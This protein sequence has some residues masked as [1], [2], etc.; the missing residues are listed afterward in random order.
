MQ[1]SLSSENYLWTFLP[2]LHGTDDLYG[3]LASCLPDGVETELINLPTKGKQDY[4]TLTCWLKRHLDDSSAR[5]RVLVAESFSGPLALAYAASQPEG[6]AAIVLGA[7]FC[8]APHNPGIALLPLRPLFMIKPP[9][10]ALEHFLIGSDASGEKVRELGNTISTISAS[11]LTKRVRAVLE[12]EEADAPSLPDI[13]ML[14]LQAKDDNLIPWEAQQRLELRYPDAHVH[15][16]PAP[17]LIFQR[18]PEVCM[19]KMQDFTRS[20]D[21]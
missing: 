16:I 11:T 18:H 5:K 17:H 13:P 2:G 21:G 9:R 10:K 1:K 7:S 4:K 14:I 8:E 3:E 15:W 20:I 12:L 6:V 19:E